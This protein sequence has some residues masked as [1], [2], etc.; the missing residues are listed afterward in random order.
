MVAAPAQQKT[1]RSIAEHGKARLAPGPT[2]EVVITDAVLEGLIG[3][4]NVPEDSPSASPRRLIG[5]HAAQAQSTPTW[6]FD[7]ADP[8]LARGKRA[9]GR[10]LM[11]GGAWLI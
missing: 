5:I 7:R 2:G 8:G 1:A 6:R 4:N 9:A 3:V 10:T 11:R